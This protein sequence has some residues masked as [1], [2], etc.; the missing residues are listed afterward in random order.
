MR[1]LCNLKKVANNHVKNKCDAVHR[2][3]VH[4]FLYEVGGI[5]ILRKKLKLIR[6]Q[7]NSYFREF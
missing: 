2:E 1:M 4:H 5:R 3:T 7:D 6:L